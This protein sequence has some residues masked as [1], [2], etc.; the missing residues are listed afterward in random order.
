[1]KSFRNWYE[2]AWA[3]E[4]KRQPPITSKVFMFA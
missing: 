4:A 2:A 1:M 3:D